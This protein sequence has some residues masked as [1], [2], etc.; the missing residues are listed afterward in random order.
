MADEIKCFNCGSPLTPAQPQPPGGGVMGLCERC[1]NIS[2]L[3]EELKKKLPR[4]KWDSS[5]QARI[6]AL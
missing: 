3:I 6:A 2:E 1:V 4:E 5:A